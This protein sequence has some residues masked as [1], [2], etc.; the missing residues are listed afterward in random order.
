MTNDQAS[1]TSKPRH[2]PFIGHWD[3]VIGH[4]FLRTRAL[5]SGKIC[6]DNQ[7]FYN[8]YIEWASPTSVF[9]GG[10]YPPYSLRRL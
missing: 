10:Q 2:I 9:L 4:F 5:A 8:S 1:M 7:V 6:C 3:L